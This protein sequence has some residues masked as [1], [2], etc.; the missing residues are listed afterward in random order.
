MRGIFWGGGVAV[1]LTLG[2]L[3]LRSMRRPPTE[4]PP[5]TAKPL[6]SRPEQILY[7]RLVRA[8]PGHVILAQVA[9]SQL[10][11]VDG[12]R[13]S[14]N[15]LSVTNRLRQLVADFVIC[16]PDFSAVAVVELDDRSHA[17]SVQR[18]RDDRKDAFLRTAGIKIVRVP[19]ND[20]P[21]E[22][23]LR[24]LVA[25]LPLSSSASHSMRRAS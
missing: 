14:G 1:L 10:L 24:A 21:S 22:L 3:A 19:G 9:L 25:T 16:K 8:F 5:V 18:E 17:R 13:T 11:V 7:G 2:G 23:A 6:L 20:I 12:A 4:E 15:A